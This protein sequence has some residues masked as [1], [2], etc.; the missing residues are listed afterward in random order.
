M[1]ALDGRYTT[2]WSWS[3]AHRE[4]MLMI[5]LG[6]AHAKSSLHTCSPLRLLLLEQLGYFG[7]PFGFE[8]SLNWNPAFQAEVQLGQHGRRLI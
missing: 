5:N 1:S 4:F 3:L 8:G 2:S 7:R 6:N